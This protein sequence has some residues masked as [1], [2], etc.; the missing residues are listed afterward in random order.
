[1]EK[2]AGAEQNARLGRSKIRPIVVSV[3]S[4]ALSLREAVGHF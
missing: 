3:A 2:Y 4:I 1:M